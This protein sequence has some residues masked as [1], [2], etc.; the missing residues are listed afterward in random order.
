MTRSTTT[1]AKLRANVAHWGPPLAPVAPSAPALSSVTGPTVGRSHPA[2]CG[3]AVP[4][5]LDVS[6]VPAPVHT[7]I[8]LMPEDGHRH[9]GNRGTSGTRP[10]RR[11][12]LG[13]RG[14][15]QQ[16]PFGADLTEVDLG[17]RVVPGTLHADH[18]AH[19]VG[20]VGHAV[21][22][23]QRGYVGAWGGRTERRRVPAGGA[24]CRWAAG[25]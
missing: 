11:L 8:R 1:S 19:A 16:Q 14:E 4:G 21:A 9:G 17:T 15:P 25:P 22:R 13:D 12:Q 23:L 24:R 6:A 7:F 5:V 10:A 2:C 18:P 3:P 20:V